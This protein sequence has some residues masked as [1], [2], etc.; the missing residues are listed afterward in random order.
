MNTMGLF[1]RKPVLPDYT[2]VPAEDRM[3][4]PVWYDVVS[5][6]PGFSNAKL[7]TNADNGNI[8]GVGG[9]TR[10]DAGILTITPERI[11]YAYAEKKEIGQITQPVQKADLS[12]NGDMFIMMF[13]SPQNSWAFFSDDHKPLLEAFKE[14]RGYI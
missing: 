7:V 2:G 11:G 9:L 14:A 10:V 5:R 6:V 12:H 8:L 13:G 4:D 1:S 3:K